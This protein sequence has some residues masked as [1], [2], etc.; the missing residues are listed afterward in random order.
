MQIDTIF[1][2]W[3]RV[4]CSKI[5]QPP[6]FPIIERFKKNFLGGNQH[7]VLVGI[8]LM[9][10]Q[11]SFSALF[12][13]PVISNVHIQSIEDNFPV[14]FSIPEKFLYVFSQKKISPR[15]KSLPICTYLIFRTTRSE[16]L[17]PDTHNTD[18]LEKCQVERGERKRSF[19]LKRRR[20]EE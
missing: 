13:P 19:G 6:H 11:T 20:D 10:G 9:N 3:L 16:K 18:T 1:A 12:F 4:I 5:L 17:D 15:I 2:W 14:L 8:R 7:S